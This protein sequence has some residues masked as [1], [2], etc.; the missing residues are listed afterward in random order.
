MGEAVA[1]GVELKPGSS[2]RE[3]ELIA[4]CRDQLGSIKAPKRV[5]IWEVLPRSSVAKVPMKDI[6]QFYWK[7]TD[8]KNLNLRGKPT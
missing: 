8:R 2:V 6:R 3:E 7:N 5:I 4:L 1:A